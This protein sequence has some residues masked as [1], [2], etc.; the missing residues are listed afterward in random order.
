M[1][2]N[3]KTRIAL[4]LVLTMMVFV[5]V[6]L[7][8]CQQNAGEIKVGIPEGTYKL[9]NKISLVALA[10]DGSNCALKVDAKYADLLKIDGMTITV[11]GDVDEPTDVTVVVY[12][13]GNEKL[14]T[15]VTLHLVPATDGAIRITS[16]S[17]Y[18][19]D[20]GKP[21]ELAVTPENGNYVVTYSTDGGETFLANCDYLSY[22]PRTKMLSLVTS[23]LQDTTVI[24]KFA[25]KTD[26]AV[27]GT[28]EFVV[29]GIVSVNLSLD[30]TSLQKATE[31]NPDADE[32]NL[33]AWATGGAELVFATSS[34]LIEV[35]EEGKG[36]I[37]RLV[38][39]VRFDTTATI[40]ASLKDNANISKTISVRLL[41][42][43]GNQ[44]PVEG[45][46]GIKLTKENLGEISN[47]S[48]TST[49][50]LSDITLT[51]S[52]GREDKNS[53]EMLVKMA[54]DRWY[55]AWNIMG[56]K[57]V[58]SDTYVKSA[59]TVNARDES[60]NIVAKNVMDRLYINSQNQ[61]ASKT[62]KNSASVPTLWENQHLWNHLTTSYL[63]VDD[64]NFD[65]EVDA[66]ALGY[67]SR[68]TSNTSMSAFKYRFDATDA[69]TAYLFA[70]I[71]QSLTPL[72]GG[73]DAI[74][75]LWV[76]VDSEGVLG[77]YAKT[78]VE[79]YWGTEDNTPVQGSEP[80]SKSWST[81]MLTLSDIGTTTVADPAPYTVGTREVYTILEKSL[82]YMKDSKSYKF[83]AVDTATR[84]P[85]VN[86]DDYN[87]SG[88][89]S[90]GSTGS[91]SSSGSATHSGK[92]YDHVDS[93]GLNGQAA[94]GTMGYVVANTANPF[95]L[96]EQVGKYD[97]S[98]D[99]NIYH[100]TYTGYK[101]FTDGSGAAYYEEFAYNSKIDGFAG[102]RIVNADISTVLP[103][104]NFSTALFKYDG[105]KV[106]GDR[107]VYTFNLIDPTLTYDVVQQMSIDKQRNSASSSAENTVQI[108][109]AYDTS[110]EESDPSAYTIVSTSYPYSFAGGTYAGYITTYYYG[111]GTTTITE[112]EVFGNKYQQRVLPTSWAEVAHKGYYYYLHTSEIKA[113]PG[114]YDKETGKYIEGGDQKLT[115]SNMDTVFTDVF[116]DNYK[117][118]PGPQFFL[119]LF[120]DRLSGPWFDY[121][122]TGKDSAG[123]YT[124][125]EEVSITV[126]VDNVDENKVLSNEEYVNCI[127]AIIAKFNK[128]N[129]AN[130]SRLGFTKDDKG[131]WIGGWTF[132]KANSTALEGFA[133]DDVS[134]RRAVFTCDGL[135]IVIENIRSPYFYITIYNAGE[136]IK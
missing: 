108:S 113:Y 30:K 85:T 124:Y 47:A 111:I 17:G 99:D 68:G 107:E 83:M 28:K 54:Q 23:P 118:L 70:Y 102:T 94:T 132:S 12:A 1:K 110:K 59:T 18:V 131:N 127:N 100:F 130:A 104:F 71:K 129:E 133:Y 13:I 29:K 105:S 86:E 42:T 134:N 31:A 19:V 24:V 93:V 60:G 109:V 20:I 27:F 58:T 65:E 126:Q 35:V 63:T 87:V 32:A 81:I 22:S 120:N 74:E 6:A 14:Y 51:V 106:D 91:G 112:N 61:L 34:D 9:G 25:D 49:G 11:I 26:S 43:R 119:E 66:A 135:T 56:K 122:I 41:Q 21:L 53:Y 114:M 128:W 52:N 72:A 10:T 116:K 96:F 123:N 97:S 92:F 36:Y 40:T 136:W 95:V 115:N 89:V 79:S 98:M 69:Q 125:I 62:V 37:V 8:A 46:N 76:I 7:V 4:L 2:L 48:I 75:D 82:S 117:Y 67:V 39:D 80:V 101:G 45:K 38:G 57:L 103:L 78:Y 50:V 3:S 33:T 77:I 55:G 84:A 16:K 5:S 88:G 121:T 44:E 90:S 64:F 15:E 73:D